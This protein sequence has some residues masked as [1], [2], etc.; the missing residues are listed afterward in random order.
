MISIRDKG[1]TALSV[2][3]QLTSI[4]I[5]SG[6]RG[7]LTTV[8]FFLFILLL[9]LSFFSFLTTLQIRLSKDSIENADRKG[10]PT[11]FYYC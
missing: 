6:A 7:F 8:S 3:G 1:M 9:L 2:D 4:S 10:I 11:C 5:G